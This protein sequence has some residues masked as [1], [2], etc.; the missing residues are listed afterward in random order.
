MVTDP[1]FLL[2]RGNESV[3][4]RCQKIVSRKA[5][6][7]LTKLQRRYVS[8]NRFY[9]KRFQIALEA[10]ADE[11]CWWGEHAEKDGLD[12]ADGGRDALNVFGGDAAE[13]DLTIK[14]DDLKKLFSS[15]WYLLLKF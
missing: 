14:I 1:A 2:E 10:V 6:K 13:P 9:P 12:V 7:G 4:K 15:K 3:L 5:V 11:N 8:L